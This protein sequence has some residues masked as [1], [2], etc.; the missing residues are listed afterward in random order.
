MGKQERKLRLLD[1]IWAELTVLMREVPGILTEQKRMITKSSEE[2]Q[3]RRL[4]DLQERAN[5]LG[6]SLVDLMNS[7]RVLEVL[8]PAKAVIINPRHNHCCPSPP[9]PPCYLECPEAAYL[10]MML[11]ALLHYLYFLIYPFVGLPAASED[12]RAYFAY[13]LCRTFAGIENS[14]ADI[15]AAYIPSFPALTIARVSCPQNVRQWLW[16]KLVHFEEISLY[17]ARPLKK[18]LAAIWDKP[19]LERETFKPWVLEPPHQQL[20]VLIAGEAEAATLAMMLPDED[21]SSE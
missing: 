18:H 7:P 12:D 17:L 20:K 11:L 5:R 3:T 13:E 15:P 16:H 9:F 6:Q 4:P 21:N 1:E 19:E 2:E 10:R 14:F 8:E